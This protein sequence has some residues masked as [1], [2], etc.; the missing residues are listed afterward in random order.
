MRHV[1]FSR[2]RGFTLIEIIVVVAI[3]TFLS[4]YL[5][6][7][8]GRSRS[9]ITLSIEQSKL[10]QIIARSKALA[11][12]TYSNPRA[13][14]GYGVRMRYGENAYALYRYD[15]DDCGGISSVDTASAGYAEFQTFLLPQGIVFV[16]GE[17]RIETALFVPP[18]P[19]V[20]LW[21][22]GGILLS[23][24]GN[25]YLETKDGSAR[26]SVSMNPGGQISF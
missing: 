18:D 7:Y 26:A 10:I 21:S 4:G 1:L 25:I 3:V 14:C 16:D 9:Q 24:S 20:F 13:P 12:S 5:L 19:T 2:K 6:V 22:D 8:T 23:S 15:S 11:I 17:A